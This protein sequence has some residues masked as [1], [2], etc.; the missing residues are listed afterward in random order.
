MQQADNPGN[1]YIDPLNVAEVLRQ[2]DS[3]QYLISFADGSGVIDITGYI[4]VF[5]VKIARSDPDSSA[6]AQSYVTA[7][8]GNQSQGGLLAFEALPS[9]L[10]AVIPAPAIYVMDLRYTTTSGQVGTLVDGTLE[11][12]Q[13][14][15]QNLTSP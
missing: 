9:L 15:T 13:P 2:G 3:L 11:M 1:P 6:V 10:S 12:I 8:S 7:P 4:F 14:V 5:T